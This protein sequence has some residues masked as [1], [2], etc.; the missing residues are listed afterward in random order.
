MSSNFILNK[1]TEEQKPLDFNPVN[2]E[3]YNEPFTYDK[4][5]K[6]LERSHDTAVGPDQI[7]Y[8]ILKHLPKNVFCIFSI[9]SGK[10]VISRLHGRR[11][12]F[13]YLKLERI[14]R[15]LIIIDR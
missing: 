12:Q 4:L 13:L 14:T 8:Q 3:C 11:L 2:N 9:I 7:H 15:I 5:L 1:N 10:M 6:S